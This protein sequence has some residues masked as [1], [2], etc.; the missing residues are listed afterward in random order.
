MRWSNSS[1]NEYTERMNGVKSQPDNAPPEYA[2]PSISGRILILGVVF[3]ALAGAAVVWWFQFNATH[4]AAEFWGPEASILI[5]DAPQVE[6]VE[7]QPTRREEAAN[8]PLQSVVISD[9][10]YTFVRRHDISHAHGLLHLRY[11]LLRDASFLWPPRRVK[12]ATT[13]QWGLRFSDSHSELAPQS[14]ATSRTIYF[15]SDLQLMMRDQRGE[16]AS[17]VLS[18]EPIAAGLREMFD[19]FS[20]KP[21]PNATNDSR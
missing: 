3:V 16:K 9:H 7:L 13:W 18:S 11:A 20:S 8:N 6:F 14:F 17:P 4:R 15:S 19:E 1:T 12:S 5:R 21:A 2:I 10:A